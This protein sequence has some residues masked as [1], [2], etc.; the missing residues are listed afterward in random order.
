MRILHISSARTLGGG[1]RHL[2][3]LA[4]TLARRGH[5]VFVAAPQDSPLRGELNALPAEQIFALRLRNALDVVSARA[6]ARLIREHEIEILHAH[7][8]RDYPLA[9]LSVRGN[10]R[11]KLVITRHVLFPLS[12][13][14]KLTLA[15]VS[16]VIA[17]SSAVARALQSQ[18]IFQSKKIVTIPNGVDLSRFSGRESA[19]AREEFRQ[20]LGVSPLKPLVG[21][22]GELRPPK[23]LEDFLSAAAL[24]TKEMADVDFV[25]A[26]RDA[27]PAGEQSAR[28][29][30][31]I[32]ELALSGRVHLTGWLNDVAPLLHALDVFVSPSHTESFGLAIVEAMACGLAVVAT[33]TEGAQEIIEDGVDGLLVPVHDVEQLA[34][35]TLALVKDEARRRE[36][37]ARARE[38]VQARF[39][40]E[41]DRKSV[42]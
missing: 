36:L 1:E 13:I 23:G 28:L 7:L 21:T 14:H 16:R 29:E 6:L 2:A 30:R 33:R 11:T 34:S 3:D 9:A 15:R 26:G 41:R 10:R 20:R 8:A 5:T 17:V 19:T 4:N 32:E 22:V 37:G 42:V 40:L 24:L 31:L 25:I 39:S 12:R 38:S 18:G 35:M 27:S